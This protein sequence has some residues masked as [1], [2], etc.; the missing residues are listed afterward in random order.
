MTV[1][2]VCHMLWDDGD[3]HLCGK[4]K[5]HGIMHLCACGA[6]LPMGSS[7]LTDEVRKLRSVDCPTCLARS[8]R[9][10]IARREH[11]SDVV[12]PGVHADRAARVRGSDA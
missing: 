10:C 4:A 2:G 9:P 1:N 8:G 11:G 6:A 5:E 3:T 7:A 12:M